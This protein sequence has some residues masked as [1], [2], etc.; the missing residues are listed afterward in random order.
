MLLHMCQ[1]R[2]ETTAT[3]AAAATAAGGHATA[4]RLQNAADAAVAR[5]PREL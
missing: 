5:A 2:V 4:C 3:P 1:L